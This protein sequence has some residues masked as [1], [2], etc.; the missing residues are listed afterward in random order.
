[1]NNAFKPPKQRNGEQNGKKKTRKTGQANRQESAKHQQCAK[2][3]NLMQN[4]N[5]A[6][7]K[8]ASKNKAS[9]EIHT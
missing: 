1:M 2:I 6:K 4:K 3:N 9:K 8:T 5:K 7:R